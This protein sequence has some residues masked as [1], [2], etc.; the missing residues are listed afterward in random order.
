MQRWP[1]VVLALALVAASSA[2]AEADDDR[3]SELAAE[4][5]LD[6]SLVGA[7]LT[8]RLRA[9]GSDLPSVRL[10]RG[11]ADAAEA[12]AALAAELGARGRGPVVCGE[13][14]AADRFVVVCAER[15]GTL[16]VGPRGELRATIAEGAEEPRLYRLA[17][18]GEVRLL[19]S[20]EEPL[21]S[22]RLDADDRAGSATLQL[23]ARFRDGPRPVA[24]V[25]LGECPV[26]DAHDTAE[27]SLAAGPRRL[28]ANA[29]LARVA[30]SHAE[31]VCSAGVA[32]HELEAGRDPSAR[33]RAAGLSARV[34]GET[35]ARAE[36]ERAAVTAMLSSPSH[37]ATWLDRR[38]TD[39]G[40]GRA[41][42]ARGTH[43][44]VVLFAAW[45]RTSAGTSAQ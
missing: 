13:A 1:L 31:A 27:S 28:R 44:V 40:A 36:S 25:C 4:A 8:A 32:A 30:T 18:N 23:V 3:L 24:E 17:A 2:R 45:P 22:A 41:T 42:D 20:G 43:C 38:F 15:L 14:R 39:V 7:R 19:A 21:R 16:A 11:R 34:V 12:R 10:V 5:L 26:F 37:R 9:S 29:L 6:P 33:L 35:V